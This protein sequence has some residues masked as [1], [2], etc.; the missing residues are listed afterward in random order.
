M[1]NGQVCERLARLERVEPLTLVCLLDESGR[2]TR[3]DKWF[4][5]GG[6]ILGAE[7]A[8]ALFRDIWRI[9]RSLGL[10]RGTPLKWNRPRGR[11]TKSVS[12]DSHE[13][14]V[15]AVLKACSRRGA[16]LAAVLTP[17]G[18]TVTTQARNRS[19]KIAMSHVLGILQRLCMEESE[20]AIV[21]VDRPHGGGDLGP[22]EEVLTEGIP[23]GVGQSKRRRYYDRILCAAV[24]SAASSR[25]VSAVDVAV[26]TLNFCLTCES[27]S[28]PKARTYYQA[29]KPI[30]LRPGRRNEGNPWGRGLII[31]P[32]KIRDPELM[33]FADHGWR[34]LTKLGELSPLPWHTPSWDPGDQAA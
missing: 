1:G 31:R 15:R 24:T 8:P 7:E 6:L 18:I 23:A 9:R 17:A 11:G 29:L 13:D 20:H 5:Y 25:L 26:G 22:V 2:E 33:D 28:V 10:D 16:R 21:L 27:A 32:R 34:R 19:L 3:R 14:A 30:I 12:T 4:V